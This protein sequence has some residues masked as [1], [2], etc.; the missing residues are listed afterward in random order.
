MSSETFMNREK[1]RASNTAKTLNIAEIIRVTINIILYVLL[2]NLI[3]FTYLEQFLDYFLSFETAAWMLADLCIQSDFQ[4]QNGWN[5]TN[6]QLLQLSLFSNIL[7]YWGF[8][9]WLFW[10]V[11]WFFYQDSGWGFFSKIAIFFLFFFGVNF[12]W[13]FYNLNSVIL[14]QN[15]P[16]WVAKFTRI[17]LCITQM[18]MYQQ[19]KK[20]FSQWTRMWADFL[21]L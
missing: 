5:A 6:Y 11:G 14:S 19:F 10:L 18:G 7:F 20:S 15:L 9:L 4:S 3:V 1:P 21:T 2:I 13:A 8:C 16:V 12:W 17:S